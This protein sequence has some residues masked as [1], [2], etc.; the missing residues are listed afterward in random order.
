MFQ[1]FFLDQSCISS[2]SS[3]VY[4]AFVPVTFKGSKW[5]T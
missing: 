1:S 2:H 3:L 4:E 5:L